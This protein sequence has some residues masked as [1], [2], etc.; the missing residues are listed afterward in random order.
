MEPELVSHEPG[1]KSVRS[2]T[3]LCFESVCDMW[4][5][6]ILI[7]LTLHSEQT[8]NGTWANSGL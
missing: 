4:S 8:F 1:R 2:L 5:Y 6:I 7:V 3:R